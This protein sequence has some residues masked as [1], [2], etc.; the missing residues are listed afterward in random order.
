MITENNMI[1]A[2]PMAYQI[3]PNIG[4]PM[5]TGL[6]DKAV[7]TGHLVVTDSSGNTKNFSNTNTIDFTGFTGTVTVDQYTDTGS[8][9]LG[10]WVIPN[11]TPEP[12]P[13]PEPELT[14]Q[15]T[16]SVTD[17]PAEGGTF[18]FAYK[19]LY[20][21]EDVTPATSNIVTQTNVAWITMS[22]VS[23]TVDANDSKEPRQA[24]ILLSL[25]YNDQPIGTNFTI[26]QQGIE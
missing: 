6:V 21:N 23:Y 7:Y 25:E 18:A 11:T 16:E 2:N 4:N 17:I 24:Q 14:I 13:E 19:V 10:K 5:N 3:F 8:V 1:Y 26:I 12:E 22:G 15:I 9:S 20:G